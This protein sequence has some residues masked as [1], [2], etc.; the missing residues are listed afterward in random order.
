MSRG[1][2][3]RRFPDSQSKHRNCISVQATTPSFHIHSSHPPRSSLCCCHAVRYAMYNWI[4]NSLVSPVAMKDT[5][6]GGWLNRAATV[7]KLLGKWELRKWGKFHK[8]QYRACCCRLGRSSCPARFLQILVQ[9]KFRAVQGGRRRL[10]ASVITVTECLAVCRV[11]GTA[12]VRVTVLVWGACWLRHV[13]CTSAGYRSRPI[14][15]ILL[16][17]GT[18]DSSASDSSTGRII[19]L[20]TKMTFCYCDYDWNFT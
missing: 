8:L 9:S 19:H 17:F 3:C 12:T 4:Q 18:S 2:V 10:I 7:F 1:Q 15:R 13:H 16:K 20:Y 5:F 11:T 14:G 6:N